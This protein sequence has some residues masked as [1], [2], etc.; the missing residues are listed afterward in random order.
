MERTT[1]QCMKMGRMALT[2]NL[3]TD[4]HKGVGMLQVVGMPVQWRSALH[5]RLN[6]LRFLEL[7]QD[8]IHCTVPLLPGK[9]PCLSGKVQEMHA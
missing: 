7:L 2:M 9:L 4:A 1:Q 3:G 8:P 5:L 6:L